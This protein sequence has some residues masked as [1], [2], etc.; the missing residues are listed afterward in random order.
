MQYH[1][2]K[3]ESH[4]SSGQ[5]KSITMLAPCN[6]SAIAAQPILHPTSSSSGHFG[7]IRIDLSAAG[8]CLSLEEWQ[9]SI[10]KGY[11]LYCGGLNHIVHDCLN[12]AKVSGYPLLSAIPK[13]AT[14][15][16]TPI[17]STTTSQSEN[18]KARKM[19]LALSLVVLLACLHC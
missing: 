15:P 18:V 9:N 4:C 10:D 12:K 17:S 16:E 3:V 19:M 13:T 5:N 1:A 8:Q 11:S 2:C 7:P 14:Q 6:I